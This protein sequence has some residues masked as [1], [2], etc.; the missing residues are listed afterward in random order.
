[1]ETFVAKWVHKLYDFLIDVTNRFPFEGNQTPNKLLIAPAVNFRTD[2]ARPFER[3]QGGL[4][5][6]FVK[7]SRTALNR[8]A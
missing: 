3:Y 2:Q 8:N 7:G 5:S 6:K 1:L 4:S